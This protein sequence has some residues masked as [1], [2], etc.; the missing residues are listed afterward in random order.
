MEARAKLVPC[1][2]RRRRGRGDGG[3]D[4]GGIREGSSPCELRTGK[5]GGPFLSPLKTK[6]TKPSVVAERDK[7]VGLR[8]SLVSR[9]PRFSAMCSRR[10]AAAPLILFTLR[11][12]INWFCFAIKRVASTLVWRDT[13][14][15]DVR[16]ADS[17]RLSLGILSLSV[18]FLEIFKSSCVFFVYKYSLFLLKEENI[19]FASR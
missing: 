10:L 14:V 5:K 19:Q 18:S 17:Q 2:S 7:S 15:Q 8:G 6:C 4:G 1:T 16:Q 9:H 11:M 3:D 12:E 13:R